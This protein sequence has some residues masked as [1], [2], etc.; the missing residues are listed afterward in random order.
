MDD[1]CCVL[2]TRVVGTT[3]FPILVMGKLRLREAESAVEL[4][5]EPGLHFTCYT[6]Q[7]P[8]HVLWCELCAQL[9]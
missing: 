4:G 5:L 9:K 1:Q 8:F 6:I 3:I 2:H 7:P